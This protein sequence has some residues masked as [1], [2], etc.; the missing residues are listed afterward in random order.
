MYDYT[1]DSAAPWFDYYTSIFLCM[2]N[3]YKRNGSGCPG[4]DRYS[5]Q[6]AIIS[7]QL[8]LADSPNLILLIRRQVFP[9]RLLHLDDAQSFGMA[10][11]LHTVLKR[12]K[13]T[14]CKTV[15]RRF[16]SAPYL[17]RRVAA[18]NSL[19]T[20]AAVIRLPLG[21]GECE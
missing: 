1:D 16:E 3:P 13:R 20:W 10:K 21:N 15:N 8:L 6:S 17:Q 7:R 14:V 9:H 5:L 18:D 4:A 11:H 2:S 19:P 12:F